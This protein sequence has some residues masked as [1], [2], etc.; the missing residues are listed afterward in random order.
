MICFDR[1]LAIGPALA[2]IAAERRQYHDL[3]ASPVSNAAC[4]LTH[5]GDRS[6][7]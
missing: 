1:L 5:D 4:S 6:S 7:T 2:Q 3:L